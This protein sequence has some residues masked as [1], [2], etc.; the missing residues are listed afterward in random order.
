MQLSDA[1]IIRRKWD[2]IT[3]KG[4]VFTFAG[5]ICYTIAIAALG[6]FVWVAMLLRV[7]GV[8]ASVMEAILPALVVIEWCI[9]F[10]GT[11]LVCIGDYF[12]RLHS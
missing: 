3:R 4:Q 11:I 5:V 10:I 12:K 2:N 7:G 6:I 9:V 1:K 8:I